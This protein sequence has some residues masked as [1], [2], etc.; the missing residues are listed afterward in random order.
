MIETL[1][2]NNLGIFWVN[3]DWPNLGHSVPTADTNPVLII[4]HCGL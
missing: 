3:R 4:L 1:E 2:K